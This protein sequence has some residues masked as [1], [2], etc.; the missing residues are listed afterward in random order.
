MD[1][2]LV[3]TT[4]RV[5]IVDYMAQPLEAQEFADRVQSECDINAKPQSANRSNSKPLKGSREERKM[6]KGDKL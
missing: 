4:D 6:R 3:L 1:W 2:K 5:E